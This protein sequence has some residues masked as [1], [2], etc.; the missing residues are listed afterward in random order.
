MIVW[1]GQKMTAVIDGGRHPQ[2]FRALISYNIVS[3]FSFSVVV[4]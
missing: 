1:S 2:Q 3:S 4:S